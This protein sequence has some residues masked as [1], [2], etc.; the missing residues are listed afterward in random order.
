MN[1]I[2]SLSYVPRRRSECLEIDFSTLLE[3][4]AIYFR[5]SGFFDN[6]EFE[7]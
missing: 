3:V 2:D 4:S 6:S 5:I 7:H 1:P